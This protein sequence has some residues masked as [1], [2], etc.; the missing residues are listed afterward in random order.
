MCFFTFPRA[1]LTSALR[2]DSQARARAPRSA[3]ASLRTISPVS[4]HVR[5]ASQYR[6]FSKASESGSYMYVISY[7]FEMAREFILP[8]WSQAAQA[9][10]L[11]PGHAN[12]LRGTL[13][14]NIQPDDF[15]STLE[16][17]PMWSPSRFTPLFQSQSRVHAGAPMPSPRLRSTAHPSPSLSPPRSVPLLALIA[18]WCS[19]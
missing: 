7:P 11:S 8:L 9:Q 1:V 13:F 18:R 10:R 15:S 5:Q 3:S 17:S 2:Y 4:W 16:S 6:V 19:P 12:I 14:T